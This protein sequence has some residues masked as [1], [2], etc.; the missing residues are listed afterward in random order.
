MVV[1]VQNRV[2]WLFKREGRKFQKAVNV[3]VHG[4]QDALFYNFLLLLNPRGLGFCFCKDRD[5]SQWY[6]LPSCFPKPSL[7]W[8]LVFSS[9]CNVISCFNSK[10]C[11]FFKSVAAYVEVQLGV[12]QTCRPLWCI[13]LA[14]GFI[15]C[16]PKSVVTAEFKPWSRLIPWLIVSSRNLLFLCCFPEFRLYLLSYIKMNEIA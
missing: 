11:L 4:G 6:R 15:V 7:S 5:L 3:A 9:R 13:S 16:E 14:Q 1:L 12:P 8:F 10:G 2:L